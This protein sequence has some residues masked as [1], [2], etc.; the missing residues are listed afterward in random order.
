MVAKASKML[1]DM[2]RNLAYLLSARLEQIDLGIFLKEIQTKIK[3][4]TAFKKACVWNS[5]AIQ[6]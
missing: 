3:P 5:C 1:R 4:L 6:G 2:R